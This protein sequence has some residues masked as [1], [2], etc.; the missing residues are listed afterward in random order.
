MSEK[1]KILF[2]DDEARIVQLLRIMFRGTHEVFTATNGHEALKLIEQHQIHVVIS[3]Q[4]MP[5]MTGIEFLT[6]VRARS[7]GT[8]RILLTGYSDL[9]AIVGCVNEGEVF[10]F[11]NKPWQQDEIKAIVAEAT[12]IALS[13]WNAAPAAMA[14]AV[15]AKPLAGAPPLPKPKVLVLDDSEIDR[16]WIT[17]MFIKDYQVFSAGSIAEALKVL[18]L[19]PIGVIISEASVNGEDSGTLLK[20]LKREYP[21]ITTVMLTQ[22]GDSDLVIKLIN[23]AQI[24]RFATKPIRKSVLELAVSGAMRQHE[25]LCTDPALMA[26]H[27]V[28]K[29]GADESN[30]SLAQAIVRGLAGFR[31][32][33][34]WF[35]SAR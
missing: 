7:P 4:R 34:A 28:A 27:K 29:S 3:D 14:P 33:F 20:L 15:A 12:E 32:R 25:R 35:A 18:S 31:S 26:R 30:S 24:Y 10:R 17:Q 11:I 6:Q 22:S 2:L 19:E 5:E 13:T 8:M 16:H 9:T 21:M 23:Q 1:P